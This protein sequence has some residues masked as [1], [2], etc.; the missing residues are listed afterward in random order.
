MTCDV[1]PSKGGITVLYV[2]CNVGFPSGI[3]LYYMWPVMLGLPRGML[4]YSWPVITS[5]IQ[6]MGEGNIFSLFTL[7]GG[8]VTPSQVWG[9]GTPAR[10]R[11][12]GVPPRPG[13]GYPPGP[14]M[15]YPPPPDLGR[16]TP[17]D[18]RWGTSSPPQTWDGVPPL[19][20]SA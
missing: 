16:G 8:G 10:S 9:G 20:R 18:L 19:D 12:W 11:W 14:G 7:A 15:E 4:L 1:W 17:L 5:R 2:A 3:L 6:R 13:M